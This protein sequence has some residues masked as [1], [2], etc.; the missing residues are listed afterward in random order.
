MEQFLKAIDGYGM[1]EL[2]YDEELMA[3]DWRLERQVNTALIRA[4]GYPILSSEFVR[5]LV[6]LPKAYTINLEAGYIPF[7]RTTNN[8]GYNRIPTR[9][10]RFDTILA[11]IL[12]FNTLDIK[13]LA[14]VK[15]YLYLIGGLFGA[16]DKEEEISALCATDYDLIILDLWALDDLKYTREDLAR[17]KKKA[18]GADRLVIAYLNLGAAEE[19]RWYYSDNPWGTWEPG[20]KPWLMDWYEEEIY[21]EEIYVKYWHPEWKAI[22]RQW[23]DWIIEAGFDGA[24]LDNV[25]VYENAEEY[26]WDLD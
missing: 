7:I 16:K 23:L 6:N 13:K 22:A 4:R 12:P 15:N 24:Y 8:Y 25:E 9:D 26:G 18:N 3:E 14:D 5:G 2:F 11:D 20:S 10:T 19:Y 21:G 1:E 17:I